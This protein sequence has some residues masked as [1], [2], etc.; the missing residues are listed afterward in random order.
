MIFFIS[1]CI[2]IDNTRSTISKLLAKEKTLISETSINECDFNGVRRPPSTHSL[3][4]VFASKALQLRRS[5]TCRRLKKKKIEFGIVIL[6][7]KSAAHSAESNLN[8]GCD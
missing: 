8:D 5:T 1:A 4:R 3:H 6:S 2:H 7:A